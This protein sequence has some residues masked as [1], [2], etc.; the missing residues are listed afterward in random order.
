M[1][2]NRNGLIQKLLG[3][4]G[5]PGKGMGAGRGRGTLQPQKLRQLTVSKRKCQRKRGVR[6]S[7]QKG[8]QVA[9]QHGHRVTHG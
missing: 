4:S 9:G 6:K 3:V 7:G 8:S 2:I 1:K 5:T